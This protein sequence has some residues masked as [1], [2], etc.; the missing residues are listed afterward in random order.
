MPG[1]LNLRKLK[2]DKLRSTPETAGIWEIVEVIR[3]QEQEKERSPVGY[4]FKTVEAERATGIENTSW[5]FGICYN[6]G[7]TGGG[8]G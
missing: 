8:L 7:E 5:R 4:R 3:T 6:V 2:E 1:F